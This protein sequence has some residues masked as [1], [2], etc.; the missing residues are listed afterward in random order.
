M[1]ILRNMA[2]I[3][4]L[5][6]TTA[7]AQIPDGFYDSLKG[8]KGS[9][10]KTAIYEVI[11]EADV[12]DYG[13]GNNHTWEGFYQTDRRD[14]NS[15]ID[16]YS[17]EEFYFS[18]VNSAVSG[19][20]I[21][22]SFPKSWWGGS[23]NQAYQDLYNLM[24]CEQ[25]INSSKSNYPMGKVTTVKTTNGCTNIG[26]GEKGYSLWEPANEW[27]GDFARGYMYMATAYQDLTWSGTQALQIL[28]QDTYPTLQKWAYTL[29][30]MWAKADP[31]DELELTRNDAVS[32]IQG[33]RNPY[34]D[35]PNL[36]EYVW[37]DSIEY[38]FDPYT[39]FCP[40]GYGGNGGTV[41]PNPDKEVTIL[42]LNLV[43]NDGGFSI[44]DDATV[45]FEVWQNNKYGWTGT[46][47]YNKQRYQAQ[48]YLVS[49]VIDLTDYREA[50]FN[51]DHIVN[52][53]SSPSDLLS[54]EVRCDGHTTKLANIKWPS[55]N[56][57]TKTN[58]GN[59]DLTEYAGKQIQIAF[60]YTSGGTTSDT[61]TW[62]V[63]TF[64]VTGKK[65]DASGIQNL[66]AERPANNVMYDLSGRIIPEGSSYRGIVIMNG[67][68]I[69]R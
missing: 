32:T 29:Y 39:S 18:S 35:F 13:S 40:I 9:E 2:I 1:N 3:A 17:Y 36:M 38:D 61:P 55:G 62:E 64:K 68:K 33:N 63:Q 26:T 25:K 37:G 20:N 14:D 16:R 10:L 45:N 19:M 4:T 56:S 58:S 28:E 51:F 48:G 49:P 31:V 65:Q 44:E 53:A 12:L 11:K 30:I 69:V 6:A 24:P 42:N 57:W 50:S 22:H 52:Y 46:A 7:R 21:E 5:S 60:L 23:K 8:K 66:P 54:V 67:K 34:V 47:Y 59:I 27:K 41:V 43:S 15:V